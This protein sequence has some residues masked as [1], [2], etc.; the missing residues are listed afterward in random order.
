MRTITSIFLLAAMSGKGFSQ[1]TPTS[2]AL[3]LQLEFFGPGAAWSLNMDSRFLK[4]ENGLGFRVGIGIT[5]LA[6]L[7]D[8]C[9]EGSLNSFPVGINYLFGNTK[10][11]LELEAGG[12]LLFMSGTKRNCL[13]ME[14]NFLSE[15]TTNYWF[16]SVGYRH[17]PVHKKG[18][19]YRVFVSPLYQKEFPVK[20]WGGGSIGFRF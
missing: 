13:N 10:N 9:N 1:A 2:H 3:Q 18:L 5:P 12:V 7:K 15:E 11:L 20:F 14:K 6:L 17:Q 8:P 19:T 16:T 4:K